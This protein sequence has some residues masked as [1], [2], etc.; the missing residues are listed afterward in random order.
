MRLSLSCS[1]LLRFSLLGL[2]SVS[3]VRALCAHAA[4]SYVYGAEIFPNYMRARGMAVTIAAYFAFAAVYVNSAGKA[5]AAIG[6]YYN[7][8]T[9]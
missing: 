2:T 4:A 7:I 1:S 5:G 8:S 3:I 9:C 6:A